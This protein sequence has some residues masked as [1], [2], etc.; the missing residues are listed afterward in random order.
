[1]TTVRCEKTDTCTIYDCPC[2]G[3]H[4]RNDGCSKPECGAIGE[5]AECVP[6]E[7]LDEFVNALIPILDRESGL[8]WGKRSAA[9]LVR[10]ALGDVF[11]IVRK[12]K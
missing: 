10:W 12:Q 5:L 9:R 8:V 7:V 6:I 2:H 3:V 11:E 1:M 4:D